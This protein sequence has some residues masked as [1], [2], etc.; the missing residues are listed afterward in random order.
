MKLNSIK[1]R[2]KRISDNYLRIIKLVAKENNKLYKFQLK[3]YKQ[4][5]IIL[6]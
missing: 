1:L 5:E 3:K 2:M 4:M 6:H